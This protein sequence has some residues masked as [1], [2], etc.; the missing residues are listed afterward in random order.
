MQGLTMKS[1]KLHTTLAAPLFV[2]IGSLDEM[3]ASCQPVLKGLET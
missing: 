2:R 1:L 3:L